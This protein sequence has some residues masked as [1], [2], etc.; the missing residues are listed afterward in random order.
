M[1]KYSEYPIAHLTISDNLI[2]NVYIYDYKLLGI[3]EDTHYLQLYEMRDYGLPA[4][5]F[6]WRNTL[7][8]FGYRLNVRGYPLYVTRASSKEEHELV[9]KIDSFMKELKQTTGIPLRQ[10]DD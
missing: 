10:L 6:D 3:M 7:T 2:W 4:S 1:D 5:Y 9:R 8:H